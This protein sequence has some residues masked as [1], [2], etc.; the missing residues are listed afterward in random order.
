MSALKGDL[1]QVLNIGKKL[2]N[3]RTHSRI[4]REDGVCF[5]TG[6]LMLSKLI[7]EVHAFQHYVASTC[8]H[9]H[10]CVRA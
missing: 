5:P 4:G 1:N 9:F 2:G 10:V 6:A 3:V 8:V 7:Q